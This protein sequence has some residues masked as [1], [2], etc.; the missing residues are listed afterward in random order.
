LLHNV[1]LSQ[2]RELPSAGVVCA[3]LLLT[4]AGFIL[5][6]GH[7]YLYSDTQIYVPII[8]RLRN[9]LVLGNDIMATRPFGFTIYDSVA[10][11][12]TTYTPLRL[13]HALELQQ[14][15]FRA[16]GTIGVFLIAL[17]M[18]TRTSGAF[19]IAA[20]VSF[21]APV[22]GPSVGTVESEPVPRG[23]AVAS[24]LLAV[25]L[26]TTRRFAW[27]GVMGSVA[28]LYH[29]LTAIPFWVVALIATARKSVRPV[30]LIPLLPAVALLL[31]LAHF[32]GGGAEA[33]DVFHRLDASEA[34]LERRLTSYL[35]VSEWGPKILIELGVQCAIAGL[36]LWRL[37]PRLD[38]VLRDFLTGL[39]LVGVLS[40]PVSYVVLELAGFGQLQPARAILMPVLFSG[41]LTC[42][43]A[44]FA[45]DRGNWIETA[46]W[47]SVPLVELTEPKLITYFVE[48]SN[49][50]W[51]AALLAAMLLCFWLARRTRGATLV[52]AGLLPMIALPAMGLV[53]N[54]QRQFRWM[55]IEQVAN[56]ARENTVE[57]AVFLFPDS[58]HNTLPAVFRARAERA[59]YVDW[60]SR[61]QVN[62]FPQFAVDWQKRWL[63][64]REGQWIV[65][66]ED[67]SRLAD[68]RVDYVV[69]RA[70]HLIAGRH[71]EYR[72]SEYVVYRTR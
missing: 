31:I 28:F 41:M 46:A 22:M 11:A 67:F 12:L 55:G 51:T 62:Y 39:Y 6:P 48:A 71:P 61:G 43:C 2:E 58:G 59:L 70:E 64:T 66:E 30:I 65:T 1:S 25:G 21:G 63:D 15:I 5:F 18:G 36:A 4:G 40:V 60:K 44:V 24:M 52:V 54:P 38:R 10:M 16:L 26:A 19:F 53:D 69:L 50:A 37:W 56:W 29:P 49:I 57:D 34:A 17:A 8:E 14:F 27:A 3:L 68:L 20:V 45:A 9:P 23:F 13:E 32:H 35:F 47:L 33:A 42:A 7:T 72:N